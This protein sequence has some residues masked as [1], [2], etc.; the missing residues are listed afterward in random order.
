M[1]SARIAVRGIVSKEA[2]RTSK[3]KGGIFILLKTSLCAKGY[4]LIV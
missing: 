3:E 2:L 1:S 4:N